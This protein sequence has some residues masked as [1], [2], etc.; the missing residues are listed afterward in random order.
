MR[1]LWIT[2]GTLPEAMSLLTGKKEERNG[3]GSWV[4]TLAASLLKAEPSIELAIASPF[5]IDRMKALQGKQIRYYLLPRQVTKYP[6][7][8]NV[9]DM[10]QE[11]CNEVKPD[12]VHIHGTEYPHGLSFVNA[13][14]NEHVVVSIQ[15]MVSV[16]ADYYL[17][18]LSPLR[19]LRNTSLRDYVRRD[20]LFIQL[21]DIR[22]RGRNEVQFLNRVK[23]VLGRTT[24][25]K[26]HTQ[27]IN[28]QVTYHHCGETL[29]EEFYSGE[30]KYALCKKHSI[31]I[32][33]GYY[34][35]KGLHK[36]L[37]ALHLVKKRYPDVHV[38]IAGINILPDNSIKTQL[39][40]KAYEHI[41]YR[42]LKK[43]NL[44]DT[45]EF[46]GSKNANQMKVEMLNCNAYVLPSSIENSPNSL[47]EAQLLGV[48][49]VASY[50]GG[51]PDM[52]PND[53]CGYMYRYEDVEALAFYIMKIFK[54]SDQF[55]GHVMKETAR[56]RHNAL[57]NIEQLL[58]I[59]R[60]V[61]KE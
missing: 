30:W 39:L 51:V 25:D 33:Q 50:V 22:R 18:G 53:D 13:C 1:I 11:I 19:I 49:C 42:Q 60:S 28:P 20:T 4:D 46:I 61:C 15:G 56:K 34:P 32:S 27:M 16:I 44:L 2:N 37:D 12:I 10:W 52:I 55:N 26:I 31:F 5:M 14:G 29:R 21:R 7:D 58:N 43:Y 3:S 23:H 17:A 47:G 48:P 6:D 9:C 40:R 57:A 24:W 36:F 35:L 45:V 54:E 41:I 38:R 59:Y 8:P